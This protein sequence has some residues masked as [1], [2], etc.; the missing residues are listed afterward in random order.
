[1][2]DAQILSDII[3][4]VILCMWTLQE[5]TYKYILISRLENASSVIINTFATGNCRF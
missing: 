4:V 3:S 5:C 2:K 1:M